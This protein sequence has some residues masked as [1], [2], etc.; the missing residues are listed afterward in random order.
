LYKEL[1]DYYR[2]Q[3]YFFK[4]LKLGEKL[5]QKKV[6]STAMINITNVY[7]LIG[8]YAKSQQ[9]AF[10]AL[11]ISKDIN[12]STLEISAMVLIGQN[13]LSEKK[14]DKAAQIYKKALST[15]IAIEDKE[16]I[17]DLYLS[18][19]SLYSDLDNLKLALQYYE[20]AI[21]SA[22]E[23]QSIHYLSQAYKGLGEVYV[24][25][26]NYSKGISTLEH[27]LALL[28]TAD[29]PTVIEGVYLAL[30]EGY[31]QIGNHKKAYHYHTLYTSIKDSIYK[32]SDRGAIEKMHFEHEL[33]KKQQEILLLEHNT[34]VK[35]ER[36]RSNKI[37]MGLLICLLLVTMLVIYILMRGKHRR[38]L[39]LELVRKQKEEIEI[40]AVHLKTLNDLK[41]KTFSII[42]HDLRNPI[43]AFSMMIELMNQKMLSNAEF[44]DGMQ[45][46]NIQ[47]YAMNRVLDNLLVWSKS[48]MEGRS[49]PNPVR[50]NLYQLTNQTIEL[51]AENAQRKKVV[52]E[53]RVD[54]NAVVYSD[55]E[56]IDIVIRNLVSNAIKFTPPNGEVII[57]TKEQ[58]ER[59]IVM[60]KDSGVGM[61]NTIKN[62]L[63]NYDQPFT[64]YG[65]AGEKGTGIGLLICKE[66]IEKNGG[67]MWVESEEGKG[68]NFSFDL[69]KAV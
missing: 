30:S 43:A 13:Y 51:L 10:S 55:N 32:L 46:I 68:S 36:N 11:G 8:E 45:K 33:Y 58:N 7:A 69:P 41:T 31:N 66:F 50:V 60:V 52:L 37:I 39:M 61:S 2:A 20:Q 62:K 29:M 3:E 56:H 21:V 28:S 27:S 24:K 48:Q 59:I 1:G 18:L 54:E 63:F 5:N 57:S 44:V 53:N 6:A 14:Y 64:N 67:K 47:F 16:M 34:I 17:A 19:A 49:D 38:K 22:E 35:E 4:G 26:K 65:T 40:Q 25:T 42:S 15:A 23:A 9:Y 12:D